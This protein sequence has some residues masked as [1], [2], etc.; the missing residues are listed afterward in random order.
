MEQKLILLQQIG[1]V[2][3]GICRLDILD[4]SIDGKSTTRSLTIVKVFLF[5]C[6]NC[7]RMGMES[8]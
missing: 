4:L 8:S 3:V 1:V 7:D 2:Y 6:Y 5:Q